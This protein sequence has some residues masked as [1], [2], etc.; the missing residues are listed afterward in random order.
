MILRYLDLIK[1]ELGTWE[2]EVEISNIVIFAVISE[3]FA[4]HELR[5]VQT[6]MKV[7]LSIWSMNEIN[8]IQSGVT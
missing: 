8:L 2:F 5:F 3:E 4:H 1:T 6:I 7:F